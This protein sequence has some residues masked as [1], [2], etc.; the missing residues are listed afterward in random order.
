M[1]D[2]RLDHLLTRYGA[3]LTVAQLA[4]VLGIAEQ[5]L[6]NQRNAGR[7]PVPTYKNGRA[8]YADTV[9]VAEYLAGQAEMALEAWH[10]QQRSLEV[11]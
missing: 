11:L 6:H 4:E 5:T 10:E 8:V 9:A 7:C 1:T 3:R 2:P